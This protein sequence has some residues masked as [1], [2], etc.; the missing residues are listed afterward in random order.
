MRRNDGGMTG[1][2][3]IAMVIA[4]VALKPV[5]CACNRHLGPVYHFRCS[6]GREIRTGVLV[7]GGQNRWYLSRIGWR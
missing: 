6:N 3:H 4:R 2:L 5:M 1:G 7:N